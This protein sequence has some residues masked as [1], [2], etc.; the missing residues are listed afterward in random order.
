MATWSSYSG[1][2]DV[3]HDDT[4][5]GKP[6]QFRQDLTEYFKLCPTDLKGTNPK[7]RCVPGCCLSISETQNKFNAHG[8]I[9]WRRKLQ[10]PDTNKWLKSWHSTDWLYAGLNVHGGFLE[11]TWNHAFA[12]IK[13]DDRR[14]KTVNAVNGQKCKDTEQFLNSDASP[15]DFETYVVSTEALRILTLH[16]FSLLS[17]AS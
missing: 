10:S 9:W 17:S 14:L 5:K 4:S 11:T 12:A 15:T 3:K 6:S 13:F 16:F 2:N 8:E 1:V 7:H